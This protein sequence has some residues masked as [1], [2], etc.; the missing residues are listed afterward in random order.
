MEAQYRTR[1]EMKSMLV[2][3]LE[4]ERDTLRQEGT[5]LGKKEGIEQGKLE[6]QRQT[7]LR[8]LQ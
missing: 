5:E 8:L 7:I 3:A 1:E 6:A 2:K 4:Q